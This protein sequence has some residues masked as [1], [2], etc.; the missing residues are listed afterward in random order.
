MKEF[1]PSITENILHQT[2]KFAKQHTNI[3]KNNL[4]IINHCHKS[5]LFSDNKTWKKRQ[6]T[7]A[8]TSQWVVLMQQKYIN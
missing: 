6:Q 4:R 1:Y 8:L 2:F 3:D 7:A 5:L